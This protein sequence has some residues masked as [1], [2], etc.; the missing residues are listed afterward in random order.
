MLLMLTSDRRQFLRLTAL[1]ALAGTAAISQ[2]AGGS[3]TTSVSPVRF[4][5]PLQPG[6]II[7][8]T[9]PSAGVKPGFRPRM[10]YAYQTL[11]RMGYTIRE[12]QCLW[13]RSLF[14]APA[15][16]RAEELQRML[17]DPSLGMVFPPNGG[18][19]L[20]DIL[21][22]IDFGS[23][24]K[25]EP[26]WLIG[27]SDL[28]TFM[29]PY[30]LKT[31]IAT[32]S[33]T[34]LWEC[35][36]RPTDPNLAWWHDVVR[37]LPG[38]SFVQ[39]AARRYQPHDSDW[40]K[41]PPNIR[42]FDRTRRVRWQCLGHEDDT[43]FTLAVSGR[44]LGGTLD[45]IGM[46][47]GSEYGD[48][49]GFAERYAPEGLLIYLDNCDYN[50]AQ[51]ARALHQLK[52]AGWFRRANAVLIGRTAAKSVE[53]FTQRDALLNALG[54]LAIPV[55]YDMDIGHLPPQLMLVNAANATLRFGPGEKSL[56]QT[57]G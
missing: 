20:I 16:Q 47:C 52:L 8:V 23:L 54:D 22:L 11:E 48:V 27:Y 44:L 42:H 2:T 45:V 32:L 24:A 15:A 49:T 7:G 50:T 34:N 21:P 3:A 25:A 12:G 17:L 33:G 6:D 56:A 30:T 14:S 31:G 5:K 55:I 19:L 40:A 18:E 37:L 4:P 51:Y 13:G 26:K 43:D 53:G 38:E 46:L 10:R 41:L 9:S 36:I 39:S 29:L 57:L 1:S 35:P 28:S